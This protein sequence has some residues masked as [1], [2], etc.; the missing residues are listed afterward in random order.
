MERKLIFAK[1][2]SNGLSKIIAHLPELA[3]DCPTIH[4]RVFEYLIKPLIEAKILNY[5]FLRWDSKPTYDDEEEDALFEETDSQFKL[6]ALILASQRPHRSWPEIVRWFEKEMYWKK[7]FAEKY[8]KLESQEAV[9]DDIRKE[10]G[11]EAAKIIVPL[12]DQDKNDSQG[13]QKT[14]AKALQK[15]K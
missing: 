2:F 4:Q 9:F 14:L 7:C 8:E 13:N 1:D 15:A 3:M 5:K 6:L 11:D 10:V 12:L